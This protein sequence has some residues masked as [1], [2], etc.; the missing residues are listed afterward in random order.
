M[1]VYEWYQKNLEG[2][3]REINKIMHDRWVCNTK[4]LLLACVCVCAMPSFSE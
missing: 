4:I 2:I 1:D 3:F